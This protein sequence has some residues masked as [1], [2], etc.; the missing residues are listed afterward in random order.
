M[1]NTKFSDFIVKSK[2]S[3]FDPLYVQYN[4][5]VGVDTFTD[6][7][8]RYNIGDL[9][10][11]VTSVGGGTSLYK[12]ITDY[13]NINLK[14]LVSNTSAITI[15]GGTDTVTLDIDESNLTLSNMSGII[16]LS[17]GGTGSALSDPGANAI[18]FWDDSTSE[19]KF[20]EIGTNLNISGT[21]LSA[22]YSSPLSVKGDIFTHN[23]TNDTRLSVGTNGYVLSADSTQASGLKWIS[24]P[25]S[26]DYGKTAVDSSA[27]P[28]YLGST[29]SSGVLRTTNKLTKSDNGNYITLDVYEPVLDLNLMDNSTARMIKQYTL[30]ENLSA[31]TF[32]ISNSGGTNGLY[33]TSDNRMN[34]INLLADT[35]NESAD[36]TIYRDISG[37]ARGSGGASIKLVKNSSYVAS[38]DILAQIIMTSADQV[39]GNTAEDTV[40][41]SVVLRT[42][43]SQPHSVSERG[44]VF[45]VLVK[46]DSQ[47]PSVAGTL[48][49]SMT[50]SLAA[51]NV[52]IRTDLG[53]LSTNESWRLGGYTPGATTA[54]GYVEVE[55]NGT[56]YKLITEA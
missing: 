7:N 53:G 21:V 50:S 44:G 42:R 4:Y 32:V 20:L 27:T 5:L 29:S 46:S 10:P 22:T 34:Y 36:F 35:E 47:G 17:K 39:P 25:S 26:S 8:F 52:P 37:A 15:T 2:S 12:E 31:G 49:M 6:E 43:S 16:P 1:S 48:A 19:I 33:F 23:G 38:G 55:I 3:S 9:A 56:V 11:Q 30:L 54:S 13:T 24:I 41:G 14:S 28:D 40:D 18:L 45:E 51:F